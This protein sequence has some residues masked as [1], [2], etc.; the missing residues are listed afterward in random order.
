MQ[1]HSYL[2]TA[3]RGVGVVSAL[4]YALLGENACG[5]YTGTT[6]VRIESAY[7]ALERYYS[8]QETVYC[9][10]TGGDVRGGWVMDSAPV[11]VDI[12]CPLT[13]P[14]CRELSRLQGEFDREWLWYSGEPGAAE[15]ADAYRKLGLSP[16]GINIRASQL[17]RFDRTRPVW[18]HMSP[19]TDLNL[20]LSIKKHWLS[21]S[22]KLRALA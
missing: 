15:E 5:W 11:T 1:V 16:R 9:R 18:V 14:V 19:G 6:D 21:D 7:F 22:G 3:P 13:E 10:S 4:Y 20:V 17:N 12:R 2:A 8:T